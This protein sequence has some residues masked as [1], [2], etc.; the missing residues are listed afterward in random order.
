MREFNAL[1]L[2]LEVIKYLILIQVCRALNWY[3]ASRPAC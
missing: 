2:N 3:Q 1:R